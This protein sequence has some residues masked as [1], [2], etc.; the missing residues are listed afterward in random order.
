MSA[1]QKTPF[2]ISPFCIYHYNDPQTNT[3][4][5]YI[6]Y[7][8]KSRSYDGTEH[9]NCDPIPKEYGP[10]SCY[11]KFYAISPML[12]VIPSGLKLITTES[13]SDAPY[14]TKKVKYAYDPFDI[15]GN[16]VSFLTWTQPVP[17]TVPLYLHIS[18][19]GTSYPSFDKL[20]PGDNKHL[21]T[22]NIIGPL[23]VLIDK[24]TQKIEIDDNL[25]Q[26]STFPKSKDGIPKFT[27]IKSGHRCVPSPGGMS[28][29]ECFLKTDGNIYHSDQEVPRNL[30]EQI[31]QYEDNHN[32]PKFK[33]FFEKSPPVV[34]ILSLGVFFASLIATII[35]L[36]KNNKMK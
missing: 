23:Y 14:S 3:Y 2:L 16:D 24:E 7:P 29:V 25:N 32:N 22:T 28:L 10:W 21:W 13:T 33:R 15:E 34:I 1:E 27:F 19:R 20:P 36:C 30:L 12:G 6:G 17:E 31:Q 5:G 9:L 35:I 11:G 4:R 26:L 18:P 8:T